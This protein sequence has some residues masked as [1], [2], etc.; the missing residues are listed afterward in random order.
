MEPGPYIDYRE[1]P[2]GGRDYPKTLLL[3]HEVLRRPWHQS[4]LEDDL[5]GEA[6]DFIWGAFD[7]DRLVG[8][9]VLQD[10]GQPYDRLR[11]MAVDSAYRGRGIGAGIARQ[12]EILARGKGKKGI[13]LMAR[14][15]VV[16]FY[17]K[18]GYRKE[19]EAFVPSHIALEHMDMVLDF[20]DSLEGS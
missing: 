8:M 7:G 4:I 3:R 17:E 2:F 20:P 10:T 13:R 16:P 18:L 5:E 9:A 12:F 11:Y 19:G 14:L 1:I 6:S 15:S